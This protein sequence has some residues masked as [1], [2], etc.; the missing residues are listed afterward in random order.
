MRLHTATTIA[1]YYVT[2][3]A[4]VRSIFAAYHL[5][6][7]LL[8][9]GKPTTTHHP[10]SYIERSHIRAQTKT[11]A[12][13]ILWMGG[14]KGDTAQSTNSLE[15]RYLHLYPHSMYEANQSDAINVNLPFLKY[16]G[17]NE[18]SN[19][20]SRSHLSPIKS[21]RRWRFEELPQKGRVHQI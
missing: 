7:L 11:Q 1:I 17:I 3:T 4:T 20:F 9:N 5:F 18:K 16:S 6:S 2:P 21:N 13:S 10:Y 12:I 15:E 14:S 19:W 8:R